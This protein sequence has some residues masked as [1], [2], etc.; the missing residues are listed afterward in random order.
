M[1][2]ACHSL[3]LAEGMHGAAPT[4][5]RAERGRMFQA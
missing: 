1:G 5:A 3:C 2:E 4:Q